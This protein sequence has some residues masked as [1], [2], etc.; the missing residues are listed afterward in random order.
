M[1]DINA[2]LNIVYKLDEQMW[3]RSVFTE[4][5]E[6]SAKLFASVSRPNSALNRLSTFVAQEVEL[7]QLAEYGYVYRADEV[8][9]SVFSGNE[10]IKEIT[11]NCC[12][13]ISRSL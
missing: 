9:Q 6:E 5:T 2:V 10:E 13:P 8:L 4:S 12:D 3:C 11:R 1:K 7:H